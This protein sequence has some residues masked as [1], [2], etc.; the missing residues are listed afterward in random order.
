M[1]GTE[2]RGGAVGGTA[3]CAPT[4]SG[5]GKTREDAAVRKAKPERAVL[6]GG[7]RAAG[8]C[9]RGHSMLCPYG[10]R[11][12]Q[13]TRGR[14]RYERQQRNRGRPSASLRINQREVELRKSGVFRMDYSGDKI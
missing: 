7:Y 3:C 4:E 12:R 6:D 2:R 1:A 5:N 9:C 14:Q 11:M 13:N 10:I 8:R